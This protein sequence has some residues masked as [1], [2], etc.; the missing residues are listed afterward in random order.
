MHIEERTL[1]HWMDHFYGYGSWEAPIW[2]VA[3]EDGGGD[4]PAE[5]AEKLNYF[6]QM[7]GSA[8]GPTLCDIRE[9]YRNSSIQWKGPKADLYKSHF[10]FRF[11]DHATISGVWKNLVAFAHAYRGEKLPEAMDYQKNSLARTN[12]ALIKLYPLPSPH[13]HSW[14]YSWLD[15]PQSGFLKS[16]E[17]YQEHVYPQR[18]NGI[19]QRL[20]EHKPDL[21]LMYG[22]SNINTLKKSIQQFS[23]ASFKSV[24]AVKQQIPHHH[25]A[26][27]NG[28]TLLLTTQIPALRHNR[29]E[30]GFD[31]KEFGKRVR[32]L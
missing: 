2:F 24:K 7:H 3:F 26:E 15:L 4:L 5:V 32:A 28:T 22:M 8:T 14:Y 18:I 20:R 19:L 11:G 23:P 10:D 29:V 30:T 12:E 1:K 16:R 21:V 6:Q 9:M 27:I 17:Q 25:R 31:W 13:N